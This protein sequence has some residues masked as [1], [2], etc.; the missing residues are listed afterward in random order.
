VVEDGPL[1]G[2]VE[3]VRRYGA[4]TIRQRVLLYRDLP[5]I[6]F[7]TEVDWH[8]RQTLLKVAFPVR[9]NALRA[10]YD[11]Q[12][13]N[14]ERPTHWN[15][16]WDWARFETVAHKWVDLSEGDYGVSLLNDCKYGHDIKDHTIRLTLIKSPISPDPEADQGTHIFSYALLP[17]QGDWRVGETVKHAYLFN[18]PST[19]VRTHRSDMTDAPEGQI[20]APVSLARTDRPGLVIDTV[21]PAEDGD[22]LVVRVV[23]QHNSRGPATITFGQPIRSAEETNLL[24]RTTGPAHFD[25]NDLHIQVRPYGIATYRVRLGEA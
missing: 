7:P 13:G 10:T 21:K 11:I 15:T 5:R 24:E 17:H 20:T 23:E 19:A 1:R 14:V 3:M 4:S 9:V 25:G 12:F 6:D 18:M 2:G 22:G 16:S 8:E